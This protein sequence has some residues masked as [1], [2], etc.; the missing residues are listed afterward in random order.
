[1]QETR[2]TSIPCIN[3]MKNNLVQRFILTFIALMLT[4]SAAHAKAVVGDIIL[5]GKVERSGQQ[6]TTDTSVFEGDSIRT[7]K[8][9]GAVLRIAHGRLEIG[10]SSEVEIV[11]QNPLRIVLKGGSIAFNFPPEAAVEIETP[12]LEIHP[13]L[14]DGNLS[15][16]VTA[17]PQTE[18]RVQ[19]RNGHFT[20]VERQKSGAANHIMPGQILVAAFIPTVR[21]SM[22]LA[23]PVPPAPQ[24]PIG[25]AAVANLT[26]IQP[27]VRVAR[28]ATPTNY[29]RVN[30]T[31]FPLANGDF[32]KTLN[33]RAT[34]TFDDRSVLTLSEGTTVQIQQRMQAGTISRRITQAIGSM[35]FSITRAAGTQTTHETPTAVAAIRGTQGTQDG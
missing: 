22:A 32:V 34:I 13:R 30:A 31:P 23:D 25:G 14:G 9:S 2:R 3:S 4:A 15:G 26:A 27:D 29:A 12:Q 18:D 20:V 1:M 11:R 21:V 33:G 19:S 8:A 17:T 6:L 35:W 24:G 5:Q 10:E 7:A 16:I 28:V